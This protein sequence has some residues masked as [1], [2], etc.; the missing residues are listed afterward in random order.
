MGAA[1]LD[2]ICETEGDWTERLAALAKAS[3]DRLAEL[4]RRGHDHALGA[5]GESAFRAPFDRM[6]SSF[7]FEIG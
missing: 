7:G 1:G 3:G 2:M 4:A 5:Y 6:F